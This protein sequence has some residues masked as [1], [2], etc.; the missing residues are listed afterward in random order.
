[1]KKVI[2]CIVVLLAVLQPVFGQEEQPRISIGTAIL[3]NIL[4]GFGVGS[5]AQGDR[6]GGGIQ[7]ITQLVGLACVG[8]VL[9][10]SGGASDFGSA[11]AAGGAA[12]GLSIGSRWWGG[13]RAK[14]Y[15]KEH[16]VMFN[17]SKFTFG[18]MPTLEKCADRGES[19]FGIRLELSLPPAN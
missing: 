11:M 13:C 4:P 2:L 18:I 8:V 19:C 3:L 16:G 1:M 10:G 5:F 7:V 17:G 15:G 14:R 12:W 9:S 6:I